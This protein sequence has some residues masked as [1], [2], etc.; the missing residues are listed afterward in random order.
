MTSDTTAAIALAIVGECEA[1]GYVVGCA[2]S[3]CKKD[4]G[5]DIVWYR[6]A[7]CCHMTM[8]SDPQ[9]TGG[10][11]SGSP[12]KRAE[13]FLGT[14]DGRKFPSGMHGREAKGGA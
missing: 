8:G 13:T 14:F 1:C 7:L 6:C 9:H 12:E 3:Q 2:C 11:H 10:Y 4:E 5:P